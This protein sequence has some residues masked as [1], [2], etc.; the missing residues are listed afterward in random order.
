[1]NLEPIVRT[2]AR[3][4]KNASAWTLTLEDRLGPKGRARSGRFRPTAAG[5]LSN[6]DAPPESPWRCDGHN[7]TPWATGRMLSR[8]HSEAPR[9]K[10]RQ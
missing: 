2:L 1:M 7:V 4:V 5:R 8:P 3:V 10:L 6:P 9:A